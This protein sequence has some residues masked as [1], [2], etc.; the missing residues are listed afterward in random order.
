MKGKIRFL[1]LV[2]ILCLLA[3]V[4][5]GSVLSWAQKKAKPQPPPTPPAD[6]AIAYCSYSS[7]GHTA[8]MVMN[9]DGSNQKVLLDG[10]KK[11][12]YGYFDPQWSPDGNW[13]V[14]GREPGNNPEAPA[15]EI[16]KK[17]GT[18][19][20]LVTSIHNTPWILFGNPQWSPD[21]LRILYSDSNPPEEWGAS[22]YMVNA[23][24]NAAPPVHINHPPHGYFDYLTIS[25]DGS[26]LAAYVND[27]P[28][29]PSTVVTH[30][31]VV[32]DVVRDEEGVWFEAVP[33]I[34]LTSA[35]RLAG[36]EIFGMDWANDPN[37]I[38]VAACHP[39][40]DTWDIYV[41][42]LSD[43]FNPRNITNTA[44]HFEIEPGWSPLGDQIVFVRDNN[45]YKMNA[46]GSSPIL[47]AAPAKN[48]SLRGPA[49][50][51]NQ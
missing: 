29:P 12:G 48:Q 11:P 38:V 43:P 24:C 13:I 28:I 9:A 27:D 1:G 42:D 4:L 14:F 41:I 39:G 5:F 47:L 32:F 3:A 37:R 2:T 30:Q 50:R 18:G 34:D 36:A 25:P 40:I 46:D 17:D 23:V 7:Y 51:Q 21:G 49:W 20:C 26:R 19:L 8:L 45:I 6:P 15:I 33:G 10:L 35:G 16:I 44:N 22:F 31:L